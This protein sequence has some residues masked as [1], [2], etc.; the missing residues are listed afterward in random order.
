MKHW[1][2]VV[3]QVACTLYNKASIHCTTCSP[4]IVQ[5]VFTFPACSRY[6]NSIRKRRDWTVNI[7]ALFSKYELSS[8]QN[9]AEIYMIYLLAE[10][11]HRYSMLSLTYKNTIFQYSARDF[12]VFFVWLLIRINWSLI[13]GKIV[14]MH[15]PF[16]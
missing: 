10:W 1:K 3:Q 7:N 11:C 12:F 8:I 6:C 4:F 9:D 2:L 15:F 16:W 14:S 13:H 5:W